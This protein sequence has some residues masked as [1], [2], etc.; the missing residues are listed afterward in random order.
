MLRSALSSKL[1]TF[2]D[3]LPILST[4]VKQATEFLLFSGFTLMYIQWVKIWNKNIL[5]HHTT[6]CHLTW[7]LF[8]FTFYDT[9]R[10][11]KCCVP[12]SGTHQTA[13]LSFQTTKWNTSGRFS[14]VPYC[15]T[16]LYSE[17]SG[18]SAL[19]TAT[20]S[21]FRHKNRLYDFHHG[22]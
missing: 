19:T 2:R 15:V 22:C 3:N 4:R 11:L 10:Y 9:L 21:L 20:S 6:P 13:L 1:L 5:T 8:N 7:S 12:T 18:E 14:H 17:P 16:L